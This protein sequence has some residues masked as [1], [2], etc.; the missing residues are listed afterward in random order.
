LGN[1]YLEDFILAAMAA[2]FFLLYFSG[3][4]ILVALRDVEALLLLEQLHDRPNG[5]TGQ[6]GLGCGRRNLGQQQLIELDLS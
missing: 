4:T 2:T 6:V 1:Y 3:P 5:P